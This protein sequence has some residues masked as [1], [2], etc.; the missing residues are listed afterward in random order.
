MIA[1]I[2]FL[3]DLIVIVVEWTFLLFL[4]LAMKQLTVAIHFYS[5]K[6]KDVNDMIFKI[7]SFV[8]N[9]EEN[10]QSPT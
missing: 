5:R 1:N 10:H 2:S 9:I 6:N 7:S 8:F 3:C 4:M